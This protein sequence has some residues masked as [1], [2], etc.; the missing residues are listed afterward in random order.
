[1]PIYEFYCPDNHKIYSFYARS[2]EQ[3]AKIPKCPDNPKFR[4]IKMVSGFSITHGSGGEKSETEGEGNEPAIDERAMAGLMQEMESA[5]TGMDEN[6][7][8]PKVLGRM[9][10]KM[11]EAAGEKITGGMEE[12]IRKLEEGADPEKLE[13]EFG[14]VL[15]NEESASGGYRRK[16]API[17]D[18]KLYDYD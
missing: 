6:N 4:M 5:M 13:E 7:P 17:R 3:A 8:D 1:M 15:E 11:A 16:A 12:M 2:R 9:M 14:D 10:R 18:P